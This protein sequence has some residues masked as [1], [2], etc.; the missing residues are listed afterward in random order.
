MIRER[1][2]VSFL[3][4]AQAG[5]QSPYSPF[6]NFSPMIRERIQVRGENLSAP[7][8]ILEARLRRPERSEGFSVGPVVH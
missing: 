7:F 1:I 8:V 3:K 2:Q 6:I 5:I 4:P